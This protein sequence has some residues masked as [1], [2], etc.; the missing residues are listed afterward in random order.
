MRSV[1]GLSRVPRPAARII[2]FM[3]QESGDRSQNKTRC[4]RSSKLVEVFR[5]KIPQPFETGQGLQGQTDILQRQRDMLQEVRIPL[6]R[7]DVLKSSRILQLSLDRQKV[8][9]AL[10]SR[11]IGPIGALQRETRGIILLKGGEFVPG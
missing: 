6:H 3:I 11:R 5:Q 7:L 8:E 1:R 9:I 10:E 2:A 4:R